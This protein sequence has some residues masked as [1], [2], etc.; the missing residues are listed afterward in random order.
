MLT[1][2]VFQKLI[3]YFWL[4]WVSV[5]ALGL[6]LVA[7]NKGY[8]LI[9]VHG[10]L[11][12]VASLLFSWLQSSMA[13]VVV[14]LIVRWHVGSSQRGGLTRVPCIGRQML[15]HWATRPVLNGC[16]LTWLVD[17]TLLK[18]FGR[19]PWS[20]VSR[21]RKSVSQEGAGR[22]WWDSMKEAGKLGER[23]GESSRLL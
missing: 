2:G 19:Q 9:A 13:S 20:C 3:I 11:T 1:K 6:S 22:R 16:V 17:Y 23:L 10:F 14:A 18:G 15:H 7:A 8:S 21:S 5:A 4:H 12:A